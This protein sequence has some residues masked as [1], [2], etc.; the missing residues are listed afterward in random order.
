MEK[1]LALRRRCDEVIGRV[2]LCPWCP[3]AHQCLLLFAPS[4][5]D[6]FGAQNLLELQHPKMSSATE[7]S[8]LSEKMVA[9]SPKRR[10]SRSPRR[11]RGGESLSSSFCSTN[12]PSRTGSTEGLS[13]SSSHSQ[14]STSSRRSQS[15]VEAKAEI[16]ARRRSALLDD[17]SESDR[18]E[19]ENEDLFQ[20]LDE[21]K[22]RFRVG[23]PPSLVPGVSTISI[24]KGYDDADSSTDSSQKQVQETGMPVAFTVEEEESY[25]PAAVEFDPDSKAQKTIPSRSRVFVAPLACL[26][27]VSG[28]FVA[29]GVLLAPKGG[30]VV[31]QSNHELEVRAVIESLGGLNT[32]Q[33][34]YQR[35]L[36]WLSSEDTRRLAVHDSSLPQRFLLA[37]IYF[38]SFVHDKD[39]DC[40]PASSECF[41]DGK[42][43]A[44]F[45]QWLGPESECDWYGIRCDGL[46]QVTSIRFDGSNFSPVT[47]G[48]LPDGLRHLPFLQTIS[49]PGYD[50][51][52]SLTRGVSSGKHLTSLN[53]HGNAITGTLSTGF[54]ASH[55]SLRHLDLSSNYIEGSL[56]LE[57]PRIQRELKLLDLENNRLTGALPAQLDGWINLERLNLNNNRLTASIPTTIG[58][59]SKLAYLFLDGNR[60]SSTIPAEIGRL[61][62]LKTVYLGKNRLNGTIPSGL[63]ELENLASVR[64]EDNFLTG[65]LSRWAGP[66]LHELDLSH[67]RL[68]GNLEVLS[69]MPF[70]L[71]FQV[72]DNLLTGSIP[73]L[74]D[75]FLGFERFDFSFNQL[76]GVIPSRFCHGFWKKPIWKADCLEGTNG[77]AQVDCP[78]CT[79]CCGKEELLCRQM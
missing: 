48:P 30:P 19:K 43:G 12:P 68:E 22:K 13:S 27:L 28:V 67:N 3:L 44:T 4:P 21:I 72:Q 10:G 61:A 74:A 41:P 6:F 17:S 73:D 14:L 2:S 42:N 75:E 35:A 15:I 64:L 8:L 69:A 56:P 1:L 57:L 23:P 24:Q 36:G 34:Y 53:L 33:P 18:N 52:G 66:N 47:T 71:D 25:L 54:A 70:L 60:F 7:D 65:S 77:Q 49:L 76:S 63:R 55:R 29:L 51:K 9:L 26:F 39:S 20:G 5:L 38:E 59:L 31:T 50:L 79:V 62:K 78:C 45:N 11:R 37:H 16:A 58:G 32:T 40:S 46:R